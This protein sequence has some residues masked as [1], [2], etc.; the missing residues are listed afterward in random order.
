VTVSDL[1]AP[2]ASQESRGRK[3]LGH[4]GISLYVCEI[5]VYII[6]ELIVFAGLSD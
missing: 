6:S 1:S 5:S 2:D 3:L 4:E